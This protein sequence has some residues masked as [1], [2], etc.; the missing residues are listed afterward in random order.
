MAREELIYEIGN[1]RW[2]DSPVV[3]FGPQSVVDPFRA[4]D[5]APEFRVRATRQAVMHIDEVQN[6]V[7]AVLHNPVKSKRERLHVVTVGKMLGQHLR[8]KFA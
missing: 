5:F 1:R 6:L 8:G 7:E 3:K 4:P 2:L